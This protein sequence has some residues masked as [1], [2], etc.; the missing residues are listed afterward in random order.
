MTVQGQ[1]ITLTSVLW[2]HI[3]YASSNFKMK[4]ANKR[5]KC[6]I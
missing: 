1:L 3:A 4:Y 6:E 2:R 5:K